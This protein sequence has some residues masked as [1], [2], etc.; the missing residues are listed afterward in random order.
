MP[1]LAIIAL[2]VLAAI[3]ALVLI[4][5][6]WLLF[7]ILGVGTVLWF[8]LSPRGKRLF[9]QWRRRSRKSKFRIIDVRNERDER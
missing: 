2:S 6:S 8:R 5:R 4:I 1:G 7:I 9:A 3:G